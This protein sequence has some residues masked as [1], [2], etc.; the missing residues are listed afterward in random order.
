[1]DARRSPGIFAHHE[2]VR[3]RPLPDAGALVSGRPQ[4]DP[5]RPG[6]SSAEGPGQSAGRVVLGG[7]P[8]WKAFRDQR[9]CLVTSFVVE[10]LPSVA[11]TR[12]C[13]VYAS[14]P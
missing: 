5:D 1:M 13:S 14:M 9:V 11:G 7:G 12:R 8:A 4:Q 6:E 3:V 10:G 2:R